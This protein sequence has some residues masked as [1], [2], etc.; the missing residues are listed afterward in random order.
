MEDVLTVCSALVLYMAGSGYGASLRSV[1]T[2]PVAED[3]ITFLFTTISVFNS[4]AVLASAPLLQLS[5][6]WG[7]NI[8][9]LAASIPFFI[10]TGLYTVAIFELSLCDFSS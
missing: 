5:Y 7:V 1:L 3:Q 2:S 4:L 9:G 8:G 10:L 6:S